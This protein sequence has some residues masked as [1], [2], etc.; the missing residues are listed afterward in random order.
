MMG[1]QPTPPPMMGTPP[2][3]SAPIHYDHIG[4][5][6]RSQPLYRV[7]Q[8]SVVPNVEFIQGIPSDLE[9]GDFFDPR[10]NNILI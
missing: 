1:T 8:I 3:L 2:P 10:I 5:H 7:I 6:S 9:D 4:P